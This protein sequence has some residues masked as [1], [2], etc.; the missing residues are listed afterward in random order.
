MVRNKSE[1]G[2][3]PS[4]RPFTSDTAQEG[5]RLRIDHARALGR[6]RE[7]PTKA[8]RGKQCRH[9]DHLQ[10]SKQVEARPRCAAWII[11]LARCAF[12][13]EARARIADSAPDRLGHHKSRRRLLHRSEQCHGR[14]WPAAAVSS[15]AG[16]ASASGRPVNFEPLIGAASGE[17]FPSRLVSRRDVK[18]TWSRPLQHSEREARAARQIPAILARI[19]IKTV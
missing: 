8:E 16:G 18:S 15:P 2:A 7:W 3:V 1:K 10:L 5:A 14:A 11:D 4:F 12:Y 17:N 9:D 13:F 19:V 6:K